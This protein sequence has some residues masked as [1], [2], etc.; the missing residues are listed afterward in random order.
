MVPRLRYSFVVDLK[1]NQLKYLNQY[2]MGT[3]DLLSL[4]HLDSSEWPGFHYVFRFLYRV[5][6]MQQVLN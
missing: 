4:P 2:R 6:E 5:A 3:S 1:T